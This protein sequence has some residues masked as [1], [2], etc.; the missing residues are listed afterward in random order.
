MKV[1]DGVAVGMQMDIRFDQC[2]LYTW[3]NITL[4]SINIYNQYIVNKSKKGFLKVGIS[5][6]E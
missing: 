6:I 4:N 2:T 5:T 1:D 3:K